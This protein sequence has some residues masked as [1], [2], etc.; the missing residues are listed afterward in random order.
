MQN[1]KF[2]FKYIISGKKKLKTVYYKRQTARY[3]VYCV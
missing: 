3:I 2:I 1:N